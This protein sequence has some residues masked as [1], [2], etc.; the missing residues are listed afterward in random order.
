MNPFSY[1][2][3]SFFGIPN[4]FRG[5]NPYQLWRQFNDPTPG[6]VNPFDAHPDSF[7]NPFDLNPSSYNMKVLGK[8][9]DYPAD[10]TAM[11]P[12]TYYRLTGVC[13]RCWSRHPFTGMFK[14]KRN[15]RINKGS[16]SKRQADT[17]FTSEPIPE[18]DIYGAPQPQPVHP[19]GYTSGPVPGNNIYGAPQPL[20][21]TYGPAIAPTQPVYGQH[22]S[23]MYGQPAQTYAAPFTSYGVQPFAP[24][25]PM[26]FGSFG[27]GSPY[28][29]SPLGLSGFN[30]SIPYLAPPRPF[31]DKWEKKMWML[32]YL[33]GKRGTNQYGS[34]EWFPKKDED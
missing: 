24:P 33:M 21:L 16:R 31:T 9:E 26:P 4:R 20:P 32:W 11:S 3:K 6:F 27:F 22:P 18:P 19:I 12:S 29:F 25:M 28:G 15:C 23:S 10:P 8:M 30:P 14:K 17:G 1:H 5:F 34:E 2:A 13:P 7:I